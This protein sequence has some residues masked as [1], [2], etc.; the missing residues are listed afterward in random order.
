M[1]QKVREKRE[2]PLLLAW[3]VLVNAVEEEWKPRAG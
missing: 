1:M 3:A 2:K